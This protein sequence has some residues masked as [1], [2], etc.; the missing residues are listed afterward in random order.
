MLMDEIGEIVEVF[1][2]NNMNITESAKS[3]YLHRN[4]LLYKIEKIKK[5]TGYDLKK[6]EDLLV[7]RIFCLI[8]KYL[9]V[10]YLK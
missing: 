6:I 10:V 7:L 9:D 2:K 3:M 8:K 4:T 1:L 5:I